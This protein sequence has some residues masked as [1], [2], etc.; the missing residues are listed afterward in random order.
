MT[1]A[2]LVA[3]IR[4]VDS[5]MFQRYRDAVIPQLIEFGCEFIVVNDTVIGSEGSPDPTIVILKFESMEAAMKWYE[6]PAYQQIKPL[7]MKSTVGWA[8][9]TEEFVMP[10]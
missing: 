3:N 10:G 4:I 2:F 6:S 8:A 9:F 1:A 7:R 5:E